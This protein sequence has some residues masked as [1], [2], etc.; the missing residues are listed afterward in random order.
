MI[1][2][3]LVAQRLN[4]LP[5]MRETW[6]QSLGQ[7]DPLEKEMATYSSILAWRMPW[8]EEPGGLHAMGSQRVRHDW[9]T[10]LTWLWSPQRK[11]PW[12]LYLN[13]FPFIIFYLN[14]PSLFFISSTVTCCYFPGGSMVKNLPANAGDTGLIPGLGR[15]P[16]GG[17]GNRSSILTRVIPWTEEPGGLQFMGSQRVEHDWGTEHNMWLFYLPVLFEL[18]FCHF[19]W[20]INFMYPIEKGTEIRRYISIYLSIYLCLCPTSANIQSS[21]SFNRGV[22]HRAP[23]SLGISW[24]IAVS[25]ALRRQLLVGS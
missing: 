16:R 24:V 20:N 2:A 21:N 14:S 11:F 22:W 17:N 15:F 1:L 3:S 19:K 5:A 12:L 18:L 9:A 13:K 7:E 10:S 23:K 8:M 6:V 4:H 25:F